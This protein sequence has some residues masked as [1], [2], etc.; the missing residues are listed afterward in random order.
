MVLARVHRLLRMFQHCCFVWFGL[1]ENLQCKTDKHLAESFNLNFLLLT[2]AMGLS[3]SQ[4]MQPSSSAPFCFAHRPMAWSQTPPCIPQCHSYTRRLSCEGPQQ[5]PWAAVSGIYSSRV[6]IRDRQTDR[7]CPP[8]LG[9]V[10]FPG[11]V[12]NP[13][14][15][16]LGLQSHTLF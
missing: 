12:I 9:H 11:H 10:A 7:Q 15:E 13:M 6:S 4:H 14:R 16:G 2:V 8:S 1:M 3:Q 5:S